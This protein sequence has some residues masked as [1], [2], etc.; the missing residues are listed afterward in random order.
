MARV[1][2]SR[3]TCESFAADPG[4][5]AAAFG[6][7]RSD[8]DHLVEMAGDLA[9]LMP[10]FVNKRERSLRWG[11]QRTLDLLEDIG[12]EILHDFMESSS[13][14]DRPG[15]ELAAFVDFVVDRTASLVEELEYGELLADLARFERHRCLCFL[16][17]TWSNGERRLGSQQATVQKFDPDRNVRLMPGA[18]LGHFSWDLRQTRAFSADAMAVLPPDPCDLLFFHNGM[19]DG[20]RILRLG[21]V[22]ASVLGVV[23]DSGNTGVTP[24]L[25]CAGLEGDRDA[26]ALVGPFVRDDALEWA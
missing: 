6:L 11:A 2:T 7:A 4:A 13:P 24:R 17:A 10:S 18:S 22:A 21:T 3:S 26:E 1:I 25:A 19:P 16:G 9:A 8:A 12:E 14:D 5:W 23:A 20:I 15:V